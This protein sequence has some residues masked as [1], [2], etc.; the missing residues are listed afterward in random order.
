MCPAPISEVR[1]QLTKTTQSRNPEQNFCRP[2]V[3]MTADDQAGHCTAPQTIISSDEM[4]FSG[5]GEWRNHLTKQPSAS[6]IAT[7]TQT[8]VHYLVLSPPATRS[9]H[10]YALFADCRCIRRQIERNISRCT[11]SSAL[12]AAAATQHAWQ[13]ATYQR[14]SDNVA[15]LLRSSC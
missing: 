13:H 14:G 4:R 6:S 1:G 5:G 8:A 12:A 10:L 15:S 2:T 11:S 7:Q 3:P 9:S